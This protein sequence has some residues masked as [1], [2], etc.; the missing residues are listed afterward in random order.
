[1]EEICS[2]RGDIPLILGWDHVMSYS[3]SVL[4]Y[5]QPIPHTEKNP[6]VCDQC[7]TKQHTIQEHAGMQNGCEKCHQFLNKF[8]ETRMDVS[9]LPNACLLNFQRI[10]T[11]SFYLGFN[12]FL[13]QP[14]F[15][16]F[17]L[18]VFMCRIPDRLKN[19]YS[20]RLS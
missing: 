19:T 1:M 17:P 16:V 12:K 7:V 5:S 6:R 10:L 11:Y 2:R 18:K 9:I 8:T 20:R 4:T 15:L 14:M 13:S 3:P